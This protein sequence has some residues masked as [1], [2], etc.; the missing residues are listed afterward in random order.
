MKKFFAMLAILL[1]MAVMA[2][3]EKDASLPIPQSETQF[4]LAAQLSKYGYANSDALS[5]IQAARISKQ[6]GFTSEARAKVEPSET[7]TTGSEQK[8]GQVALDPSK[9]LADAKSMANNDGVLLALID[10][11]ES[12][13]RGAVNSPRYSDDCVNAN[14]T[15]SYNIRFRGGELAIVTVIG[16]GDTDLDLYIYDE[17]GNLVDSDTDYTDDCVCT[18]TPKW[19]GNFNIRIKNRGSVYNCYKMRTN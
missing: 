16:D 14:S 10:D 4:S 3:E 7:V 11:V 9:L 12:N 1:P 8:H 15:D 6:L 2:Q 13:V 17:N 19:T 18:W 5:L